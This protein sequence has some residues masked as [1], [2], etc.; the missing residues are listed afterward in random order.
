VILR[1]LFYHAIAENTEMTVRLNMTKKS[2]F[3]AGIFHAI[4]KK[5]SIDCETCND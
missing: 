2:D 1:Q 5:Q 3:K 4:G